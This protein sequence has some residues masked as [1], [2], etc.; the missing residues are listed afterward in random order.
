MTQSNKTTGENESASDQA[1]ASTSTE[2]KTKKLPAH[3]V[4]EVSNIAISP[5]GACRVYFH[6][7]STHEEG[8]PLRLDSELIMTIQSLKSMADA[9]PKAIERA[10]QTLAERNNAKH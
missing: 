4:D 2:I 10:E 9:L 7:W 1:S 6:T 3:F 5:N 8:Q